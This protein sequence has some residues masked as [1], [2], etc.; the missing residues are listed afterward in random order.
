MV[1]AI[2]R[3]NSCYLIPVT[4]KYSTPTSKFWCFSAADV[5]NRKKFLNFFG[6]PEMLRSRGWV[7]LSE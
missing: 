5:T 1:S 4:R 3:P 7:L 6:L 2:A